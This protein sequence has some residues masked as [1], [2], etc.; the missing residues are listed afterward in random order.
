VTALSVILVAGQLTAQEI[1]IRAGDPGRISRSRGELQV[2]QSRCG[3]ALARELR[4]YV[5]SAPDARENM[6][7]SAESHGLLAK[8]PAVVR[9]MAWSAYRRGWWRTQMADDIFPVKMELMKGFGHGRE[10]RSRPRS[11]GRASRRPHKA[12]YPGGQRDGVGGH[13]SAVSGYTM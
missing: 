3:K 4:D 6:T 11:A 5:Q 1:Q 7:F 10:T 9:K 13:S 8:H 12:R 2:V